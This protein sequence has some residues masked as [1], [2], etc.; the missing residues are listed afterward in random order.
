[1][2]MQ[3]VV[4]LDMLV[5]CILVHYISIYKVVYMTNI[6]LNRAITAD[7]PAAFLSLLGPY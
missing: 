5:V 3:T 4:V 1:M 2:Y 7:L 6:F